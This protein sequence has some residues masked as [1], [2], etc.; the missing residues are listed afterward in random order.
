MK[1]Q[2]QKVGLSKLQPNADNPRFIKDE[3]YKKLKQSLIDFPEMLELR[4][5]VVDESFTILGGN[6][7]YRAAKEIGLKEVFITVAEGLTDE[8]KNE[9]IIKDNASF[10]DWDWDILANNWSD[11][12]LGDWGVDVWKSE[13]IDMDDIETTDNFSLPDGD[14]E[15]FQQMTFTLADAQAEYIKE[16]IKEAKKA[17][18]FDNANKYGNENSN[19]NALYYLICNSEV[20][21]EQ[22]K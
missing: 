7:R 19:G 3:K 20:W 10:G 12:E 5:I 17:N 8:Q 13:D 15:P 22:K 4:P 2:T 1:S 9:F 14:K 11:I 6:M 16:R 18:D 21:D